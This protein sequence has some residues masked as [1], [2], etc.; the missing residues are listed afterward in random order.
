M[1]I[2]TKKHN[3]TESPI[4][5]KE[6]KVTHLFA[7]R[8]NEIIKHFKSLKKGLKIDLSEQNKP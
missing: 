4:E 5:Y 6:I 8:K 3:M 2:H 7:Y 1:I